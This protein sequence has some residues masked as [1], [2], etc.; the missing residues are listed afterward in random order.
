ML[1]VFED[2]EA[3]FEAGTPVR[4]GEDV[5]DWITAVTRFQS[6]ES[7]D[8]VVRMKQLTY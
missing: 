4:A 5:E 3:Q 8:G 2:C 7:V 6:N 1:E